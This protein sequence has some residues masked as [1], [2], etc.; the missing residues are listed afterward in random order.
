MS[1]PAE[2]PAGGDDL[3]VLDDALVGR[4]RAEAG[5]LVARASQCVFARSPRRMPAAPSS[6]APRAHD[7]DQARAA[8]VLIEF[9]R[10]RSIIVDRPLYRERH[11][12]ISKRDT[13]EERSSSRRRRS[14]RDATR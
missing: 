6:S 9:E 14:E 3:A 8:A 12:A 13:A 5:E 1:M 2:T 11:S 7:V 10:G 4:D